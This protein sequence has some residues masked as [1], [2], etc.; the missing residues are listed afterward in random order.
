MFNPNSL[1][2]MLT[3]AYCFWEMIR[4]KS[5][6]RTYWDIWNSVDFSCVTFLFLQRN[7]PMVYQVKIEPKT[8]LLIPDLLFNQFYK[9]DHMF[10]HVDQNVTKWIP[11]LT[12]LNRGV[13][14][15]LSISGN[16]FWIYSHI[17]LLLGKVPLRDE[18]SQNLAQTLPHLRCPC[19]RVYVY[20]CM[21][22]PYIFIMSHFV[23]IT[24]TL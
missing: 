22:S 19:D 17:K 8:I 18:K 23:T 3:E 4:S 15:N 13:V 14:L 5:L 10:F 16:I 21:S 2:I 12:L 6:R 24:A 7:R 9:G 1:K 11:T 20:S